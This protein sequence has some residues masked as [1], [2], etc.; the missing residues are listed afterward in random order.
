MKKIKI[1]RLTV[2]AAAA[3]LMLSAVVGAFLAL[4]PKSPP[5]LAFDG[6][7]PSLLS[8]CR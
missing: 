6:I 7:R 5:G 8:Q 4:S 2:F 1:S 3:V